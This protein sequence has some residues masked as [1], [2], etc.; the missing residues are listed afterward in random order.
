VAPYALALGWLARSVL[1][2]ICLTR[3]D[4]CVGSSLSMCRGSCVW[5]CVVFMCDGKYSL[6]VCL[7]LILAGIVLA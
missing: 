7:C 5:G 2:L 3:Q 1:K 6:S 4:V